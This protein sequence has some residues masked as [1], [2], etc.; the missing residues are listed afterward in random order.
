[1]WHNGFYSTDP[2]LGKRT[3]AQQRCADLPEQAALLAAMEVRGLGFNQPHGGERLA[4][5][6]HAA[7]WVV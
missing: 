7:L 6:G 2:L 5:M 3:A 4:Q 1:M